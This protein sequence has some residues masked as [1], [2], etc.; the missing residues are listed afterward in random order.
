[1][2]TQDNFYELGGNSLR[3]IQLHRKLKEALNIEIP[4]VKLF[5][6]PTISSLTAYLEE[7]KTKKTAEKQPTE[8]PL[9]EAESVA[10]IG[11]AGRF[12]GAKNINIFWD[13]LCQGI[14]S[15]DNFDNP[16][17]P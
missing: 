16:E 1:V 12:P 13:N 9:I 6:Y 15:I 4:V 11:I 5:Q 10:I 8:N 17:Y 2:G 7:N 3:L 14:E